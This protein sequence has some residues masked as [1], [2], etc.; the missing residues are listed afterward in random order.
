[1]NTKKLK[2]TFLALA[3]ICTLIST[4]SVFAQ[5]R[6]T[7]KG[8]YD[9]CGWKGKTEY[10]YIERDGKRIFDGY[11]QSFNTMECGMYKNGLRNG[12]WTLPNF[13]TTD[14][15]GSRSM[16]K[17]NFIDGKLNGPIHL[18]EIDIIG[19]K[20]SG[21]ILGNENFTVSYKDNHFN[22]KLYFKYDRQELSGQFDANGYADGK[23]VLKQH[24]DIE[25]V[26][27]LIWKHGSLISH[28]LYD[29]SSFPPPFIAY[30]Q[31]GI[32]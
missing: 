24:Y 13:S 31:V 18:C 16:Y 27:T 10:Q 9:Y 29:N 17:V 25:Y 3:A 21:R 30:Q 11:F 5:E 7:Y 15:D 14:H 4:P 28:D 22:G 2:I 1:M 23:W 6:K 20:I 19:G 26:Q 8:I 32:I 12:D